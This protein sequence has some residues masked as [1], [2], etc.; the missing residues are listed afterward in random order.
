MIEPATWLAVDLDGRVTSCRYWELPALAPPDLKANA[1]TYTGDLRDK[2]EEAVKL[3]LVSDVP[4][5]A[6]LSG[7]LDSSLIAALMRTHSNAAVATF[8][9]GFEGDDS[10]DETPYAEQVAR[11]LGTDHTAFRVKADA[12]ELLPALVWHHDQPFADSSAIPTYLVSKLTRQHATVAL[13]GDGGDELF[14]GYERFYAADLMRK[15]GGVPS[16]FARAVSGLLRLLPEGT[17][18]YDPI[19]RARR[20]LRAASLPLERA[21]FDLVRVF[22]AELLAQV[23]RPVQPIGRI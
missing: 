19:K 16:P 9:I 2:L 4:L 12:L 10:F 22:D 18:Y 11:L 5:G 23:C 3:R 21:Y 1:E 8:S 13:S 20:F 7:G 17:G 15:L 14:A 6:F